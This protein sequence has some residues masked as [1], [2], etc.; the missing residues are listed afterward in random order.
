M[1]GADF[2]LAKFHLDNNLEYEAILPLNTI[3]KN[4][5]NLS[6]KNINLDFKHK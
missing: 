6:I 3:N 5:N 2:L 1:Y 4:K